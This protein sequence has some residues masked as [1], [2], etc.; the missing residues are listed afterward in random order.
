LN[1]KERAICRIV[2][3]H[4]WSIAKTAA[5]FG[6]RVN[7]VLRALTN[8]YVPPDNVEKDYEYVEED[9]KIRYPPIQKAGGSVTRKCHLCLRFFNR[10]FGRMP[11]LR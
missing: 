11:R 7:T 2:K 4:G 8:S 10:R 5:I 3:P 1:R 9:F 6:I